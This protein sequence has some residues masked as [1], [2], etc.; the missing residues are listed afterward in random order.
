MNRAQGFEVAF[1]VFADAHRWSV[2]GAQHAAPLQARSSDAASGP[3]TQRVICRRIREPVFTPKP[4]P[5]R[6][7]PLGSTPLPLDASAAGPVTPPPATAIDGAPNGR[8]A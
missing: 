5:P 4:F 3:C 6:T 1:A 2:V 7:W 8:G